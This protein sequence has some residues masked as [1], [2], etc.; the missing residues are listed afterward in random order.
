MGRTKPSGQPSAPPGAP[1]PGAPHPSWLESPDFVRFAPF[2]LFLVIGAAAGKSFAGSEYWMY[3]AK[4]VVVGALLWWWRGKIA[5]M[6]WAFSVEGVVVGLAI[7]ALWIGLE[8]H[9]PSLERLW[10]LAREW[11]GGPKAPA[12]KPPEAWNPVAYF[13]SHPAL[14][15]GFVV[16]RVLGRSLVVPAMEEVFYRS[17]MYRYI[18]NAR[19]ESVALGTFHAGAFAITSLIFGLSHADHWLAAVVCAAAYQ[20]LVVHK[21]RLGDAMLAHAVTNVA[22]SAYAIA[23][24]RWQFS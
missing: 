2:A 19:F 7:A 17:L 5:E 16:L 8:G 9:V 11:T 18:V 15:W 4:T 22:I 14:G 24:G 21:G 3:A 6:R 20:G 13:A 1:A 12:P 23:T 10:D